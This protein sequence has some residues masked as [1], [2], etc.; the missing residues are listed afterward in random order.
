MHKKSTLLQ[1]KIAALLGAA[2]LAVL[3]GPVVVGQAADPV[4]PPTDAATPEPAGALEE[5]VVTAQ[6]RE[7]SMNEVPMSITALGTEQLDVRQIHT[8]TDLAEFVPGM[9]FTT[10]RTGNPVYT[11]RGVGF[12]DA[13]LAGYPAVSI[14]VDEVPLPFPALSNHQQ[15]DIARV[16]VLKGPQGTLFGQN[17]TGGAINYVVQKPTKEFDAGVQVGYARFNNATL[18]GFVSGPLTESIAM[19]FAGRAEYAEGWQTS[20]TRSHDTNGKVENYMG[21]LVTDFEPTDNA[22]FALSL[23]AWKDK[24]DPQAAQYVG[25]QPNFP[26]EYVSPTLTEV[27]F[28]P[29]DSRAANWTP[30]MNYKDNDFLLASLRADFGLAGGVALT[31][32][33]SY[34]RYDQ[35]QAE[36]VDGTVGSSQ[37]DPSNVGSIRSFNQ[38]LRLANDSSDLFRWLLGAN[39]E[40]SEVE[41]DIHL[42]FFDSAATAYLGQNLGYPIGL[43]HNS[44][45]QD[46]TNWAVFTSAEYSFTPALILKAGLRYTSNE[47]EARICNAEDTPPYWTGRFFYDILAGGQ[48]GSYPPDTCFAIN[49]LTD[50]ALIDPP[51]FGAPGEF[52]MDASEDNVSWTIGPQWFVNSTMLYFTVSQGYKSGNFATLAASTFLQYLPVTQESV[53]AYEA[54]A[55]ATLANGRVQLNGAIFY[56]DYKDK[57]LL[58]KV[59]D[60]TFGIL[61]VLQNIPDSSITGAEVELTAR[62]VEPL[63]LSLAA[64]YMDGTIDNFSGINN[65]GVV[66]D[67]SGTQIPATPEWQLAADAQYNF[68]A[69]STYEAYV[70]ASATYR[71]STFSVIGGDIVPDNYFGAVKSPYT[72]D[73]YTLVNLRAGVISGDGRWRYQVWGKNVFDEYYWFDSLQTNADSVSRYAGAPATYGITVEYSFK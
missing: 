31:S 24:S 1:S 8:I 36:D 55:K 29:L 25:I 42:H 3:H 19:R 49:N 14:Y 68:P 45:Q 61:D 10:T 52:R 63:T 38:E 16:E 46:M 41:Q 18:E 72:V 4:V 62:P 47:R 60:P 26:I 20:Y 11:L 54:G 17:S 59:D 9:S 15:F 43:D 50:P 64:T 30:G 7:Q 2:T 53:L 71:S 58:S 35:D 6:K 12:Y 13:S 28:S 65:A 69:F 67:F 32:L 57:Q 70:G 21:R 33:T 51:P 48:F 73:S 23:T 39:Y 66:A 56:Y 27:P 34:D 22:K 37:D 40:H 5:I 44:S